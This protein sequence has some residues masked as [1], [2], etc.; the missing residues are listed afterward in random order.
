MGNVQHIRLQATVRAVIVG[1]AIRTVRL[2]WRNEGGGGVWVFK[3]PRNSEVLQ[4]RTG[5]KI[6]QKMFIVPIPTS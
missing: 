1:L 2:R 5:L 3:P 4:S 6:E